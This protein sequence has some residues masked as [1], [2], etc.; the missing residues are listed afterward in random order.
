MTGVGGRSEWQPA[1]H[2]EHSA[3]GGELPLWRHRERM[4][5]R[6]NVR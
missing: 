2:S 6:L 4:Q 1:T 3:V 5:K